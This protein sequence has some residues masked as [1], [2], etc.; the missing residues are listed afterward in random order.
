[1]QNILGFR[2]WIFLYK[3]LFSSLDRLLYGIGNFKITYL[4]EYSSLNFSLGHAKL[5]V[6]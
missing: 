3:I 5:N 6:F 4:L 1:M 2:M